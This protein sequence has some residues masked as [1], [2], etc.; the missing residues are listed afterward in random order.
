M[1]LRICGIVMVASFAAYC[2]LGLR[3]SHRMAK[4]GKGGRP[5]VWI[6]AFRPSCYTA[7]GQRLLG[8]LWVFFLALPLVALGILF[9]SALI[10]S[11]FKQS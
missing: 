11:P 10:C 6:N 7:E 4:A 9:L 3:I 8:E 1:I 2:L 5:P